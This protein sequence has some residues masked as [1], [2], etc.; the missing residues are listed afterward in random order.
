MQWDIEKWKFSDG[1][2]IILFSAATHCALRVFNN[3]A[4]DALAPADTTDPESECV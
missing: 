1:T 3:A 2:Q 4:I